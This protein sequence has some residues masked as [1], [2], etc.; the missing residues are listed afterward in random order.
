MTA[1]P[2]AKA[3]FR[4]LIQ[5]IKNRAIRVEFAPN[6]LDPYFYKLFLRY[7]LCNT[8][9]VSRS[10]KDV[11]MELIKAGLRAKLKEG[12]LSDEK[13]QLY[14]EVTSINVQDFHTIVNDEI[15]DDM[16]T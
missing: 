10:G 8:A 7:W 15:H 5:A 12:M 16:M 13:L 4:S 9:T 1:T 3:K 2:S 11:A 14:C 6:Q